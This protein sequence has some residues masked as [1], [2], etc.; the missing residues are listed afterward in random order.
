MLAS[1]FY[2][3]DT[4]QLFKS[5][6]YIIVSLTL[7]DVLDISSNSIYFPFET[8]NRLKDTIE[9]IDICQNVISTF[10]RTVIN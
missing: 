7:F 10:L 1:L 8:S 4:M 5:Q 6:I 9:A 2:Y 3:I